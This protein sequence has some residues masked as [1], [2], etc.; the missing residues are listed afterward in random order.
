MNGKKRDKIE[1]QKDLSQKEIE[2]LTKNLPKVRKY[3]EK[4]KIKKVIFVK[5]KLINFVVE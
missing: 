3:L 4:K 5:N 2:N 1:V